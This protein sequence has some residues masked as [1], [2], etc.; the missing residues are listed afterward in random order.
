MD[1]RVK[2]FG[3][4]RTTIVAVTIALG[5]GAIVAQSPAAGGSP[6]ANGNAASV[7]AWN[8]IALNAAVGTAK[9]PPPQA[10]ITVA[11]VQAAVYDAVVGILGGYQPYL[12]SLEPAPGASVDAAVATAAHGV[13]AHYLPD[14]LADL[15]TAYAASLGAIEDGDAKTAGIT[16]GQA[17]A[18][19]LI[20]A[21]TGDGYAEASDF[22]MPEPGP[23]V[24]QIPADQ[25][26][27]TPWLANYKP[28]MI[29]SADQFRPAPPPAL[30]S[31]EWATELNEVREWG[32]AESTVRNPEQALIAQFWSTQPTIQIN[33][34]Y[35]QL[36]IDR[37][38]DALQT[39][40]LFAMTSLVGA[41]AITA[42]FDAKYH[43]LF[44]RPFT[45]VPG[46]DT[47]DND[48]TVADPAWKPLIG[49]PPHPEYPSAHSCVTPSAGEVLAAFLGSDQIDLTLASSVTADAMPTRHYATAADL[50]NE[51]M[52][53]RILGGI[54]YRF[55][56]VVGSELGH[57]VADWALAHYFQPIP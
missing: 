32:G 52:E 57:N 11:L 4:T 18:D 36:A 49:T 50:G 17:T 14:Q 9:Q 39:A 25:K 55:S 44:W 16:V 31:P 34:G 7:I 15:D 27:I 8:E 45:A 2:L 6:D 28:F 37:G 21:R 19:A 41:D 47:D 42:C 53:A 5:M 35:Q 48:A 1:A 33:H 23:G 40:R 3:G 51:V 10:I 26:P 46:A 30:T 56:T 38:L 12:T 13:L 29:E 43:Y 22:V 54:H 24:W 20:A